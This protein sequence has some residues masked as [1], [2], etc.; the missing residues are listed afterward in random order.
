VPLTIVRGAPRFVD[1]SASSEVT[2]PTP[3]PENAHLRFAGF[4][5]NLQVSFD[6]GVTWQAARVQAQAKSDAGHFSSY[7]T[8]VPVGVKSVQIRGQGGW[9][10]GQWM[11]RDISIWAVS[12][13]TPGTTPGSGV[14]TSPSGPGAASQSAPLIE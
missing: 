2:F 11:V 7:W 12:P 6:G 9:W 13:P 14:S 3:A 1:G 8:P 10:G 5:N 4:G